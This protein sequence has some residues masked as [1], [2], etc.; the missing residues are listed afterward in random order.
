MQR[1]SESIGALAAALAK[2]QE[3]LAN[4]E[5]SLVATIPT[6]ST[7]KAGTTFRY[8]PLSSGLDIVRKTLG[9]HEIATVQVTAVDREQGLIK[10][11]TLLAHSTGEW[12]ASD[13]P[14]CQ[15]ADLATPHR[16]GA[17]LT[18]ARR[19]ALFTLVGIAGDDD[20]DAPDL[21]RGDAPTRGDIPG[22]HSS[23]LAQVNRSA[24]ASPFGASHGKRHS[25]ATLGVDASAALREQLLGEVGGL[26]GVDEMVA[27]AHRTLAAKNTL[28]SADARTIE[29]AFETRMKEF[30]GKQRHGRRKAKPSDRSFQ[31]NGPDPSASVPTSIDGD[32]ATKGPANVV[33]KVC[34]VRDK[35]HLAF[36]SAQPCLVC[37]RIPSD[38]HHLRFAQLSALGRKVSDEFSVPLCRTHHR[39][40]HRQ[41]DERAWWEGVKIDPL[42]VARKLWEVTRGQPECPPH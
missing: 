33:R 42:G 4:P 7:Q 18:Y 27:W 9:R 21:A 25:N 5:K 35:R 30:A 13:W 20:L 6:G 15:L 1:S 32:G 24:A 14:V 22:S 17:A 28:T 3:E 2:A 10:L 34:R 12:I 31:G 16:M 40:A 37:G 41:G 36:V 39:E 11:T 8:A 19:Y 38:A 23:A 29:D 26:A